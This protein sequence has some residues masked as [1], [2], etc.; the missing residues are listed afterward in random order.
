MKRIIYGYQN[1]DGRVDTYKDKLILDFDGGCALKTEVEIPDFLNPYES[2]LGTCLDYNGFSYSLEEA[3]F[4]DKNGNPWI[5][6]CDMSG[7]KTIKLKV[8]KEEGA[9]STAMTI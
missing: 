9:V 6:V 3:L 4:A 2:P 8:I 1:K 5:G 7:K